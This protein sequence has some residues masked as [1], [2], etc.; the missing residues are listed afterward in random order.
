VEFL[1]LGGFILAHS[2]DCLTGHFEKLHEEPSHSALGFFSFDDITAQC[3]VV[4][5]N[6]ICRGIT[7]K[8][9]FSRAYQENG[10]D[11]P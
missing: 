11:K 2:F 4:S 1:N 8:T 10:Q 7:Y 3:E 5:N 9:A 6:V